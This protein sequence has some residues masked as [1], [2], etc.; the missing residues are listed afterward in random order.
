M[1]GIVIIYLYS[2]LGFLYL[3]SLYNDSDDPDANNYADTLKLAFTSTLN[4]GLRYG[5]GI[6]DSI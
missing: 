3:N 5:G 2:V 6:G 1:L 4:N